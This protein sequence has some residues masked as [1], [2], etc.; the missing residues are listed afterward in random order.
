V[1]QLPQTKQVLLGVAGVSATGT[2]IGRNFVAEGT[3][4][5]DAIVRVSATPTAAN[6][7]F[8]FSCQVVDG[9]NDII[10]IDAASWPAT[11]GQTVSTAL[12]INGVAVVPAGGG[13]ISVSCSSNTGS[14]AA[15]AQLLMTQTTPG[16]F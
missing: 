12:P 15:T 16:V 13:L 2:T 6:T 4:A 14:A 3:Y 5:V 11:A 8:E 7:T 1:A 10:G 9:N